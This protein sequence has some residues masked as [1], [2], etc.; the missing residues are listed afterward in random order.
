MSGRFSPRIATYLLRRHLESL[1][2]V[3]LIM[4]SLFV[5]GDY[6]EYWRRAA[7]RNIDA[8]TVT[9]LT[10]LH[11]PAL[12]EILLPAIVLGG[13]AYTF[14]RVGRHG[15]IVSVRASGQS[16]IQ[17]VLPGVLLAGVLGTTWL[18][19]G[20]PLSAFAHARLDHLEDRH[21]RGQ[22]S[23]MAF[24]GAGF[25]IRQTGPVGD[26]VIH[27]STADPEAMLLEDVVVFRFDTEGR[28]RERADA[29]TAQLQD[30]EHWLLREGVTVNLEQEI[31]PFEELQIKSSLTRANVNEG[32]ASPEMIPLWKIPRYIALLEEYGFPSRRHQ[33]QL[34]VLLALPITLIGMVLI[35]AAFMVPRPS[36]ERTYLRYGGVLASGFFLYLL[37]D[38]SHAFGEA[39]DIPIALAAWAPAVLP[40]IFGCAAILHFE[41]G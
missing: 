17:L 32:F 29:K 37:K 19:I 13:A 41:D 11:I 7:G 35:A 6:L 23:R 16:W 27:A 14:H 25:W 31:S 9:T 10:G 40:S 39:T 33:M 5:V 26:Q 18:A 36:T 24:S 12:L 21:F 4:L 22:T 38:L 34:H 1:A 15:E 20:N 8:W 2:I 3:A 28:F 30:G